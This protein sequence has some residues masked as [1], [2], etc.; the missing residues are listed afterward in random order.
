MQE[1]VDTM[2]SLVAVLDT[3]FWL[4]SHVTTVTIGYGAGLLAGAIGHVTIL[5]R[6]FGFRRND[7][8]F[9]RTLASMTYG[10]LC[11][12]L[13]FSVV[14]TVLG[15][16]WAN[17]SWG[18]FWGWDPKENGALAIVLWGLLV[19]HARKGGYIDG[20]AMLRLHA[21][22]V[23]SQGVNLLASAAS[24]GFTSGSCS[25]SALR[26]RSA[27]AG[28]R[29]VMIRAPRKRQGRRCTDAGRPDAAG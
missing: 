11:F 21:A 29:R 10:M 5:G 27:H 28:G 4:A 3:N 16:I 18:R 19:L 9:Y 6:L 26:V 25:R 14:G 23:A 8:G 15:G 2:P 13:L 20:I 1:A 7:P 24:Y 22:V 17:D 12:G